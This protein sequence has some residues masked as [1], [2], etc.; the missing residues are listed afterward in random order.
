MRVLNDFWCP[1][2]GTE[3]EH[4]LENDVDQTTCRVCGS[5]ARKVISPINFQLDGRDSGFPTAAD[6]WVKQR[7]QKMA[8]EAIHNAD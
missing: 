8:Q 1:Q 6:K 5:I 2:C 4:F 7:E 3:E